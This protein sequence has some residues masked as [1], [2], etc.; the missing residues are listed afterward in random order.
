[1]AVGLLIFP[2]YRIVEW[3]AGITEGIALWADITGGRWNK[4]SKGNMP[5]G[6]NG[7]KTKPNGKG[8]PFSFAT[9]AEAGLAVTGQ[10][11][12]GKGGEALKE[13]LP[14]SPRRRHNTG[15]RSL[16]RQASPGSGPTP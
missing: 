13:C 7:F 4:G 16:A 6:S 10:A 12:F 15:Q 9:E 11:F 3:P 1:M 2:Y 5:G 14:R 8:A